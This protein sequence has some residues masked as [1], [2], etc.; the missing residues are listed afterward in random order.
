MRRT[1]PKSLVLPDFYSLGLFDIYA[2][3][4]VTE[5]LPGKVP[6]LGSVSRPA[7]AAFSGK[8]FIDKHKSVRLFEDRLDPVTA[9]SAEQVKAPAIRLVFVHQI[10]N[11]SAQSVNGFTHIS[12]ACD[13]IDPIHHRDVR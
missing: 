9:S 7:I 11:Y 2:V 12:T 1:G 6:H 3:H 13:D 8:T 10:L 5:L 4:K